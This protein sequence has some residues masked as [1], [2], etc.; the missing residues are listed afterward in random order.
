MALIHNGV[1]GVSIGAE[2]P[3]LAGTVL[4]Q[5]NLFGVLQVA[6]ILGRDFR[7]EDNIEGR[8]NVAIITYSLW[9]TLF[10]GDP[11]V[12]GKTVRVAHVPRTVIGVLP[13][14][15]RFPNRDALRSFHSAQPTSSAPSPSIFIPAAINLSDFGWNSDYGNWIAIARLKPGATIRQADAQLNAIQAQILKLPAYGGDRQRGTLTASVQPLQEAVVG[16][17]QAGLWLLMTAVLAFLLI[18]CLNLANAQ[19]A[20]ALSRQHEAAMRA[21]LGASKLRL[22]WHSLAE[23]LLLGAIGGLGG[24]LFAIACIDLSRDDLPLNLPRLSEIHLNWAV[25]LFAAGLTI[26]SSLLFGV[27][28]GLRLLGA[29]PQAALQQSSSRTLSAR[30]G[31][32]TRNTLIGIQVFGCTVLLLVTAL[33]VESLLHLLQEPKGFDTGHVALAEVWLPNHGYAKDQ[34]RNEFDATVLS[35]LRGIPGVQSAGL[36]SVMP[37]TGSRWIESMQRVDRPKQRTPLINLRW[38]SAGYFQA[39]G[40]HLVAGR[41]F[42][43]RDLHLH[44]AILS[45]GEAR[46]LFSSANPIGGHVET[47]SRKFTVIGVVADSRTTSLKT[48]PAKMAYLYYNDRPPHTSVF[49]ARGAQPADQLASSMRRAIWSYAPE[50][51]IA[52]IATLSSQI[53]DSLAAERFQTLVLVSFGIAALLLA[54]LGIYGVLSY[55]TEMRKQEIGMRMALGAT[56]R[57]IYSLILGEAGSPVIAGLVAGLF[58]SV[59]ASRLVNSMLYGI[60]GVDATVMLIVATLFLAAAALAAFLPARRAATLDPMAV[61]RHE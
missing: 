21:A 39:M 4:A 24:G 26:A 61:L 55:S 14:N 47:E 38:A 33:F 29:D 60:R 22:L 10:H 46:A 8:N 27:L 18:A 12:I 35:R 15:F 52:R 31:R 41:F 2:H 58:A 7:A 25:L 42:E 16:E 44:S 43:Q 56:R 17:S 20:R 53:D 11:H 36:I 13:A 54:M 51:T 32:R 23:N 45:E 57:S 48:A 59:L 5:S 37:L 34:S 30:H 1:T 50:V 6:P 49:V 3:R 19:L 28:P 40:E 9:Q